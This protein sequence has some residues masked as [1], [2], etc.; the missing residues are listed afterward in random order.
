[1][2]IIENPTPT[3]LIHI[4]ERRGVFSSI[5]LKPTLDFCNAKV[6]RVITQ[7]KRPNVFAEPSKA[8]TLQMSASPNNM[9]PARVNANMIIS[10]K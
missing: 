5:L 8:K 6:T 4:K 7:R 10:F 1:M 2:N 9:S 3:P